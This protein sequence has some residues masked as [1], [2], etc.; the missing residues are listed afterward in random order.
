MGLSLRTHCERLSS[1]CS[2]SWAGKAG[3]ETPCVPSQ[4]CLPVHMSV[5]V[6]TL[7]IHS[8]DL[9]RVSTLFWLGWVWALQR[10]IWSHVICS[11]LYPH[12]VPGKWGGWCSA[13]PLATG[14]P[15]GHYSFCHLVRN[16]SSGHGVPDCYPQQ[17]WDSPSL[18]S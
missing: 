10:H 3:S 4:S 18:Q 5:D 2:R 9:W 16:Y 13:N 17:L 12:Q 7:V 15:E 8:E 6:S 1:I 14:P 11:H